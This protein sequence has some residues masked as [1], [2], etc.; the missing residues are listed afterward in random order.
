MK[1]EYDCNVSVLKFCLGNSSQT[2]A[3]KFG[4]ETPTLNADET[5]EFVFISVK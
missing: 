5:N 2:D 1:V 4:I 3:Y